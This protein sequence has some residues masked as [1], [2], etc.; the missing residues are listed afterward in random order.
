MS[1]VLWVRGPGSE[2]VAED[3]V[4]AL[5]AFLRR[6][7]QE[8]AEVATHVR[9]HARNLENDPWSS[10]PVSQVNGLGQEIEILATDATWIVEALSSY[11]RNTAAQE[12]ARARVF[13]A[14]AE[15]L[16][17]L[18]LLLALKPTTRMALGE[19]DIPLVAGLLLGEDFEPDDVS[20]WRVSN[21]TAST[22]TQA[23]GVAQRIQRIPG[24]G[25]PIRIERYPMGD[26]SFQTEV[27]IAG[28]KNWGV[29][30]TVD[31]FDLESNL[32]LVAGVSAAS[33]V[34]VEMALRRSGVK[35]GD[36]VTFVGHSQGGVIATRLA[37][38]GRYT[39]TG[40]VTAGAPLG[41]NPV[42]GDYPSVVISHTD[43]VV[44]RLAGQT[45]P[46]RGW[47][48]EAHSGGRSGDVAG[49]HSLERYAETARAIDASEA[50]DQWGD[51]S[52]SGGTAKPTLFEAQ[53]VGVG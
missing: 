34:A 6:I 13:G 11:A 43:D 53:R 7:A 45:E 44:P 31:P 46:Q 37:E 18:A 3:H 28:T 12:A 39:T 1:G 8:I 5:N 41:S 16:V 47:H 17:A 33:L 20:V 29:G 42:T 24:H 50:A 22:V 38:S 27:F 35:S 48:I 15:R 9:H 51:W 36:R 52:G 23:T 30:Q 26:G 32:A 4:W 49:A 10:T 2:Y 14:P 40:L 25:A 21:S 19:A